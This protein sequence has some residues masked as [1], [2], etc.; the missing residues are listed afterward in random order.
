MN[1]C[2]AGYYFHVPLLEALKKSAYPLFIVCH[3]EAPVPIENS[4]LIGNVGLE[5]GCYNEFL[6]KH[7]TSGDVLFLHDDNE[8]TQAALDE[9]SKITQDQVFL[10]GSEQEANANGNAHGRAFFCSDRLLRR[11]KD[12]GGFWYNEAPETS[13]VIPATTESDPNY[14]NLG[15]Q[16]FVAYLQSLKPEFDTCNV[17]VLAGLKNGYR[18]RL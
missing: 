1:L 10:F 17:G 11:M 6:M 7:W 2:I 8:I 12:D 4:V 15:I 9:C 13:T 5:F 14:H 18:G 16:T 3:R